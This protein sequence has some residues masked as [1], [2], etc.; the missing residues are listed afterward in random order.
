MT[1]RFKNTGS[2]AAF[3]LVEMLLATAVLA[4]LV[5]MVALLID[6]TNG[7]ITASTKHIASD[8]EARAVFD[9]M[10]RDFANMPKRKD[11]DYSPFYTGK[12]PGNDSMFFYSEAPAFFDN[13][14]ASSA[15]ST[16]ALVGYCINPNYQLLRLGTGLTWDGVPAVT[17]GAAGMV[18]LP[19]LLSTLSL[20]GTKIVTSGTTSS[21]L[22]DY[23]VIGDGVFRLEFNFQLKDG[24]FSQIPAM[25]SAGDSIN[26]SGQPTNSNGILIGFQDVSAIVVAI[27]ILDTTSRKMI[28]N[29]AN[30]AN[31]A[32]ALGE[33]GTSGPPAQGWES[34]INTS[35]FY[36]SVTGVPQ[37]AAQ[38]VRIYQRYFYL[39][40]QP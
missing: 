28:T 31:L 9:H 35:S 39:N 27:A 1:I 23:H 15:Q 18:F 11:V 33:S 38:Q 24:T 6:A 17:T 4:L 29:T 36:S 3:T 2:A 22:P 5:V 13:N 26:A 8:E 32:G 37:A 34:A 20:S 16:M 25:T 40:T 21:P 19:S 10:A 7:A 30:I 12:V 14:P